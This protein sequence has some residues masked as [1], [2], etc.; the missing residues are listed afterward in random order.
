MENKDFGE[1]IR[2][3]REDKY[4]PLIKVVEQL[5]NKLK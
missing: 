3:L 4:L 1:Y 2:S 5:K